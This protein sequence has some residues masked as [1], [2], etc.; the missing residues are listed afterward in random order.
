VFL[1]ALKAGKQDR[2]SIG[3]FVA[4]YD[5]PGITKQ[6]KFTAEGEVA[7]DAVYA[8]KVEGGKLKSLGIIK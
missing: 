4:A 8:Y 3:A 7:G 2:K 5:A 6:I 1:A